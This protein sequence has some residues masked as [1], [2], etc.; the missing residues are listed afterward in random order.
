MSLSN[1]E[2]LINYLDNNLEAT[3][4]LQ[5]EELLRQ[6]ADAAK[7]LEQLQFSVALIREAGLKAQVAA[8][9][10]DYQSVAKVVPMEAQTGNTAVVRSLYK[11]VFRVAAMV[12]LLLGAAAIYKYSATDAAG[13]F[14]KNYSS[15]DLNTSRGNNNDGDIE[16]AYRNKD[17]NSV[18]TIF[19]ANKEN[20][21]KAWFLNGMAELESKNYDKAIASFKEV[22]NQNKGKADEYF[23]DE[24]EYYLAMSS[25]AAG[26]TADGVT[27]L[28]KIRADK[29]HL[30][31]KKASEISSLDLATLE[32]KSGK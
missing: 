8:V 12:L 29:N 24:A 21:T 17:W 11:N 31:N 13:V 3:D 30:F 19:A 2:I 9:R 15:F 23:Q 27:I 7:D 14:E 1:E 4:R 5:V 32:L 10:N 6:D 18:K 20:S 16:K 22:M 25:L 26:R 28:K